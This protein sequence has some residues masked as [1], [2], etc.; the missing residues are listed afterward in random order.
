MRSKVL[1]FLEVLLLAAAMFG[2]QACFVPAPYYY[3][4]GGP[5]Y[6]QGWGYGGGDGGH[7][8]HHHDDDDDD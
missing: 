8:W 1:L 7:Y 4:R 5:G 3:G 2:A 6:Y